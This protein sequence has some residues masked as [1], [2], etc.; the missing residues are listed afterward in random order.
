VG[1]QAAT[2]RKSDK[3]WRDA[4]MIA[5]KRDEDETQQVA[6]DKKAP[7]LARIAAQVVLDA[8]DGEASAVKEIGDRMDGKAKQQTELSGPDGDDVPVGIA[9]RIIGAR[10]DS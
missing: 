9:V 4:L 3:I 7:M 8:L 6:D 1:V 5:V 2:R 10:N